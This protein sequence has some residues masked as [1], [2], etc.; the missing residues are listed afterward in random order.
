MRSCRNSKAPSV[1]APHPSRAHRAEHKTRDCWWPKVVHLANL[2]HCT[3][4]AE[5]AAGACNNDR[6][7]EQE[8]E[9]VYA[10]SVVRGC[11][12]PTI[13][14]PTQIMSM[15]VHRSGGTASPSRK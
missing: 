4:D 7:Q 8:F 3:R 11:V 15:P 2:L 13:N 5:L 10:F 1:P 14:T 9:H 12:R 6:K